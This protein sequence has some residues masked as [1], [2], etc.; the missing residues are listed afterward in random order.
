MQ[1]KYLLHLI[2]IQ[3]P[4]HTHT[5]ITTIQLCHNTIKQQTEQSYTHYKVT[6]TNREI[7]FFSI[8]A[9]HHDFVMNIA[10]AHSQL[11]SVMIRKL[12]I[13]SQSIEK[14]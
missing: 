14:Y 7:V 13:I 12:I 1:M 10:M 9:H 3:V 4:T 11:G 5:Y 6:G 8:L 2:Y